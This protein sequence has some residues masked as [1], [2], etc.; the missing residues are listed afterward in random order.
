LEPELVEAAAK[1]TGVLRPEHAEERPT[2]LEKPILL[3]AVRCLK[4]ARFPI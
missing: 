3:R 2:L 4:V 1:R